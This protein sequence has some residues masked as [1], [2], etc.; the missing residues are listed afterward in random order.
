MSEKGRER[1]RGRGTEFTQRDEGNSLCL[2]LVDFSPLIVLP[3]SL[4]LR[5]HSVVVTFGQRAKVVVMD[6]GGLGI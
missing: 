1:E 5:L 2:S 6:P 3:L 4:F